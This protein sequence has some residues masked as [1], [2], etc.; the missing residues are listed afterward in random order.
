MNDP[1]FKMYVDTM[2]LIKRVEDSECLGA[3]ERNLVNEWKQAIAVLDIADS[4]FRD[5]YKRLVK[6]QESFTSEQI[7]FICYQIG[8]WYMTWKDRIIIDLKKGQHRLG[9]AKEELKTIICGD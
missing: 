2:R 4:N 3:E 5:R 8:D 1:L 9:F 7:D 6:N